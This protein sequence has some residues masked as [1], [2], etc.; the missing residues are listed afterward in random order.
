MEI[1]SFSKLPF[2]QKAEVIFVSKLE[3]TEGKLNACRK[4]VFEFNLI[5]YGRYLEFPTSHWIT[6]ILVSKY[7]YYF[8]LL[9]IQSMPSK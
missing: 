5:K 4:F 9:A 1:S 6:I 7:T 8:K 3:V 2:I